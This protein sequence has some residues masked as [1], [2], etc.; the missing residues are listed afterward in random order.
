MKPGSLSK[1][2]DSRWLQECTN[3]ASVFIFDRQSWCE[4]LTI[5]V[6]KV[7]VAGEICHPQSLAPVHTVHILQPTLLV[8]VC[9][10]VVC[11]SFFCSHAED[12]ASKSKVCSA[13]KY[14]RTF[15]IYQ[16]CSFTQQVV[17]LT[18]TPRV[19]FGKELWLVAATVCLYLPVDGVVNF[20]G[21]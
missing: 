20:F 13:F 19:E 16:R 18:L 14:V 10:C 17:L 1:I 11:C 2:A 7:T 6:C 15:Q 4:T 5:W 3:T 12:L 8:C 21:W 9:V